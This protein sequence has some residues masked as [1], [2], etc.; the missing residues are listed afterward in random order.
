MLT[1]GVDTYITVSEAT[2]MLCG[3]NCYEYWN[4]LSIEQQENA[5]RLA[6]MRID[7]L[8]FGST[9]LSSV[10]P[11]E[12][13]R[14]PDT[15]VPQQVRIAQAFE[16]AESTD[17]EK[18]ER[19]ELQAQGVTSINLGGISESYGGKIS[20]GGL[21]SSTAYKLLRKYICGSAVIV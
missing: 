13:P 20:N 10:Q 9:K 19:L 7:M 8:P 15:T 12:F 18:S 14:K 17:T 4:T 21:V 5:L 11:L 6:A 2:E 3:S 16:A 1:V